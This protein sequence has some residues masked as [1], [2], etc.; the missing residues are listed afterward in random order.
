MTKPI[1]LTID[2]KRWARGGKNGEAALLNTDGNMCCLGF[3]CKKLGVSEEQLLNKSMPES[4]VVA[5]TNPLSS[6]Q[7]KNL[8]RLVTTKKINRA[9]ALS[10]ASF[11]DA[12][13]LTESERE[14]KVKEL[15]TD[16]GFKVR[17][18]G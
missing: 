3:A 14:T 13:D 6:A 4:V 2:R 9:A 5:S 7:R 8:T 10:A 17:F 11:N 18:V 15:L 12:T 16:L 1:T